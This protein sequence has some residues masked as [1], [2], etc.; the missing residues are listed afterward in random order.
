MECL[1]PI[2]EVIASQFPGVCGHIL[3]KYCCL[4]AEYT[5]PLTINAWVLP[6][7][8]MEQVS[9]GTAVCY[10]GW[11]GSLPLFHKHGE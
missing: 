10:C 1:S 11:T 6:E 9:P 8:M 5:H 3:R 2:Q 4:L 7:G